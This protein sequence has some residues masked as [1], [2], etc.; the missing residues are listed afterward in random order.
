M[1][2]TQG[3]HGHNIQKAF[4]F[5]FALGLRRDTATGEYEDSACYSKGKY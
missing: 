3:W 2:P 4:P 1:A 5:E